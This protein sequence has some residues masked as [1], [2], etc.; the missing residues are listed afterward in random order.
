FERQRKWT[1]AIELYESALEQ[2]PAHSE[3]RH[4]LRLCEIHSTLVRRYQDRS[5]RNVLLRLPTDRALELYDEVLE[6][7]ETHYVEPV[8]L[9]P[10]VRRG[11]D[12]LEV[13]LRDPA[14]LQ[15]H[16]ADAPA[17]R[18]Q[19]LRD[20]YRS[21]REHV[22]ARNREEAKAQVL[23]ACDLARKALGIGSTAV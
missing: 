21:R 10:L 6:R 4:R 3:F 13:A 8:S 12:N 2:W 1:A 7:I 19:W 11:L 23:S 17:E 9:E 18:V 15:V 16:A 14:F 20:S 22:R 5:F